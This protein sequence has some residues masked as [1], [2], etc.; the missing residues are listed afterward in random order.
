MGSIFFL[1]LFHLKSCVD[2]IGVLWSLFLVIS[3]GYVAAGLMWGIILLIKEYIARGKK[4][5]ELNKGFLMAYGE[6]P[7]TIGSAVGGVPLKDGVKG[8]SR[9]R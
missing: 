9:L 3:F 8:Y 6:G 1:V 7:K 5:E 2:A 4:Y